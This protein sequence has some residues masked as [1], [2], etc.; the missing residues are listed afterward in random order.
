MMKK[1]IIY[2][3]KEPRLTKSQLSRLSNITDNAG[4]VVLAVIVLGKTFTGGL[5]KSDWPVVVS[6]IVGTAI[7][8][9]FSLWFAKKGD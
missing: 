5:D 7:L 6:G 1:T 4:Q 8:W 9:L 2:Q 3:F